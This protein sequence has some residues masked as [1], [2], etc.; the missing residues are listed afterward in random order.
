VLLQPGDFE[1]G[2]DR[3]VGFDQV[4]LR[5][6]PVERAAQIGCVVLLDGRRFF[7]AQDF[8][9]EVLELRLVKRGV[10]RCHV[11]EFLKAEPPR[12]PLLRLSG[13]HCIDF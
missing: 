3:L 8:L 10:S 4:A 11:L 12:R 2:V 1:V 5:A 7:L 13:F 9:H 6:Q